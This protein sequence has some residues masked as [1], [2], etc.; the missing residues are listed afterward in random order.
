MKVADFSP[1]SSPGEASFISISKPR[2][3]AQRRYIRSSISAQ[4]WE[5]VPPAPAW[6]VTTASPALD[7][8]EL[9]AQLTSHL[10]V[11]LGH[12]GEVAQVADLSLQ[13]AKRAQP[14]LGAGV[15]CQGA[16]RRILVIPEAGT[17]HPGL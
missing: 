14:A 9:G 5:S 6:T 13:I 1:A 12:L 17:L 3:S 7:A 11:L 10:L 4:S 15:G 2:R 8:D 16:G